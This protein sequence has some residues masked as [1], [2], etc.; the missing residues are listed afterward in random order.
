M[1]TYLNLADTREGQDCIAFRE[2]GSDSLVAFRV[3]QHNFRTVNGV[4]H[5]LVVRE[6][7]RDYGHWAVL[8]KDNRRSYDGSGID[9]W[10]GNYYNSSGVNGIPSWLRSPNQ[11]IPNVSIP[12]RDDTGGVTNGNRRVFVLS[13]GEL[14]GSGGDGSKVPYFNSNARRQAKEGST[15]REY[16]TRTPDSSGGTVNAHI[17]KTDGTLGSKLQE[18]AIIVVK[19]FYRPAFC[20]PANLR[21]MH[22]QG[23]VANPAVISPGAVGSVTVAR[24]H[25]A[26]AANQVLAGA[27]LTISWTAAS[28]GI[29]N[30]QAQVTYVLQRSYNGGGWDD[31]ASGIQGTS[32]T[33]NSGIPLNQ[34]NTV[35]Y[36]VIAADHHCRSIFSKDSAVQTVINNRQPTQPGAIT[37]TPSPLFRGESVA[38][39]WGASTDP[40]GHAITYKVEYS[41]DNKAA[42]DTTKA[43]VTLGDVTPAKWSGTIGLNWPVV[44]FRVTAVDIFGATSPA[45]TTQNLTLT[46]R[47]ILTVAQDASSGIRNGSTFTADAA[48]TVVFAITNNRDP[49]MTAQYT[50]HLTLNGALLESRNAVIPGGLYTHSLTQTQWQQ[51][52]NGNHTYTLAV[53][54]GDDSAQGSMPMPKPPWG[55]IPILTR[56]TKDSK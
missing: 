13:E 22:G 30:T 12:I 20:L 21:I 4:P 39:S 19:G 27:P 23:E 18:A 29:G 45:R 26:L 55:C 24:N 15:S 47:V 35:Q 54:R 10:A 7:L 25:T 53:T 1:A 14:F 44:M 34:A 36:R 43:W 56:S 40:D 46:D 2:N 48:R 42:T 3:L 28:P 5:T 17:V 31:V 38:L 37:A 52:L 9:K 51:I 32:Y 33:I 6:Q 8:N 16:W 41:T 11:I 50:T 49:D